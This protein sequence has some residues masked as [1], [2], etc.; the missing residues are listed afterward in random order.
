[1]RLL[2]KKIQIEDP[3]AGKHPAPM[4]AQTFL[5]VKWASLKRA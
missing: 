5:D 1:M 2:M 3:F 4:I